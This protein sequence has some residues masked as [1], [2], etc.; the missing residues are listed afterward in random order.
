M[1]GKHH[2]I[3]AVE[4]TNAS[5]DKGH[6]ARMMKAA[7]DSTGRELPQATPPSDSD[8]E[9]PPTAKCLADAGY[10]DYTD[11]AAT[12]ALGFQPHVALSSG[13]PK[14]KPGFFTTGD[15]R[16]DPQKDCHHCPKGAELTRHDDTRK[17]NASYQIYYNVAALQALPAQG[18]LHEGPLPQDPDP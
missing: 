7:C 6:L 8:Q 11:I 1:D 15:F 2:L 9:P 3:A 18:R 17:G 12:E 10:K 13:R 4:V 5:H 14:A 16:H